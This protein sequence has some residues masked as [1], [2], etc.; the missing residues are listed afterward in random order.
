MF[1]HNTNFKI[2]K[3][4]KYIFLIV[5]T[6]VIT[7]TFI[8][9]IQLDAQVVPPVTPVTPTPPVPPTPPVVPVIGEYTKLAMSAFCPDNT[10]YDLKL[11]VCVDDTNA[12]GTFTKGITDKCG[13]TPECKSPSIYLKKGEKVT[14][15]RY[16][17]KYYTALRGTDICPFGSVVYPADPDFCYE[18]NTKTK[19][20][21]VFGPMNPFIVRVCKILFPT[22]DCISNKIPEANFKFITKRIDD[23]GKELM[24]TRSFMYHGFE[25]L[26]ENNSRFMDVHP[27]DLKLQLEWLIK[28]GYTITT[29]ENIVKAGLENK[30]TTIPKKR[31]ILQ[32]DDGYKTV[33][34]AIKVADEVAKEKKIPVP[35]EIGMVMDNIKLFKDHLT[36]EEYKEIQVG[37]HTIISHSKSHC[38]LGD[39]TVLDP[40]LPSSKKIDKTG[41]ECE[42]MDAPNEN[43][44]KPLS[45]EGFMKQHLGINN[46]LRDTFKSITPAAIYPW[47]Q[48]SVENVQAMKL[49]GIN[50]G[51]NTVAQVACNK[52]LVTN[53]KDSGSNWKISRTTVNGLHFGVKDPRSWFKQSEARK[54]L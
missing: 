34:R 1:A 18:T 51:Y 29:T 5:L 44:L 15:L 11:T 50:Y 36:E 20:P 21:Q 37:G 41:S 39:M 10:Y 33:L 9:N 48:S 6:V 31:A 25:P 2:E 23:I 4:A 19:I 22:I 35:L 13:T 16:S 8:G 42:F 49:L 38:S 40:K 54:C 28:N 53:W 52:D 17:I 14:L 26:E 43:N 7:F 46:Y 3:T 30:F 24:A 47:G 32:L 27:R 45:F 12:Y